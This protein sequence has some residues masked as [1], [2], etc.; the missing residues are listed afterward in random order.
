MPAHPSDTRGTSHSNS[1]ARLALAALA[2]IALSSLAVPAVGATTLTPPPPAGA[3]CRTGGEGTICF[4]V[5]TFTTPFPLPYGV[6]CNGFSVRVNLTVERDVTAFYDSSG[7]L[8]R[9]IRH[10]AFSGTL[11]NNLTGATVPHAG[12]F[13]IVD[14]LAAGTS[15]ITGML[16]RTVLPGEGLIWR[17]IGRVVLSLQNGEVLFEAG[18]HGTWDVVTDP[19]TA[20]EL[21]AALS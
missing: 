15:T 16:S 21:C 4:W 14:D 11:S 17:N 12:H 7:T 3:D 1:L 6:T 19:A 8:I 18:D 20:D 10:G 5:E 9:R 2:A 13:T